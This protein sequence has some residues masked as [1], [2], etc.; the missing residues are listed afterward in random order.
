M[1]R[2]INDIQKETQ[3]VSLRNFPLEMLNEMYARLVQKQQILTDKAEQISISINK[4]LEIF[5]DQTIEELNIELKKIVKQNRLIEEEKLK[6]SDLQQSKILRQR[7]I[8]KLGGERW[9]NLKETIIT[10]LIIFV[11]G[12]MAY[13]FKYPDLSAKT[14][15][16]FFWLDTSCCLIFLA[17]FFFELRL[18]DKK[19]WY[20]K[21]HIIDFVTSIPLPDA[22]ILRMGR[23]S[24]LMRLTRIT[25]LLRFA[26]FARCFRILRLFRMFLFIWRGLDQLGEL[27]DVKLMT[28]SFFYCMLFLIIGA[29][30]IY[31]LEGGADGVSNIMESIWWSFTTVVTGGFGDIYNPKTPAGRVLTVVLIIAGM[32]LVGVF[33]ATL[34]SVMVDE[35]EEIEALKN[36]I[37]EKLD[38]ITLKIEELKKESK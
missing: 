10:I 37:D 28:K 3:K 24:R 6:I 11:L 17:N 22:Q 33:T 36:E 19:R 9:L 34:T 25:R 26:R 18:A 5:D 20:W 29:F 21:S 12:L 30:A 16:L 13:E 23:S 14:H 7:L 4:S 38:A 31:Y 35:S 15:L 27:F 32:I 2:T 8:K 1:Y